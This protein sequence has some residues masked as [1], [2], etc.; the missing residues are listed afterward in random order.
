M[1]YNKGD[2]AVDKDFAERLQ[3]FEAVWSRVQRESSPEK[4]RAS[5][6]PAGRPKSPPRRFDMGRRF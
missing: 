4:T 6:P 1:L 5:K 3:G 2:V